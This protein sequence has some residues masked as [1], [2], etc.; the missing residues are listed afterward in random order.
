M[1]YLFTLLI[2]GFFASLFLASFYIALEI[3]E[4]TAEGQVKPSIP[5]FHFI[6]PPAVRVNATWYDREHCLNCRKDL[7]MANNEPLRNDQPTCAYDGYPL[8]TRL[9]LKYQDKTA[10]CV[11]TDRIG[12]PDRIDLLPVVFSKL[13]PLE[14]GIIRVELVF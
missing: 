13:A 12:R 14:K 7:L 6:R 1:K 11:I 5:F 3:L 2:I 10:E 4:E 9:I 8:G